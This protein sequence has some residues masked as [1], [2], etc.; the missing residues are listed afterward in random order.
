MCVCV[1][2]LSVYLKIYEI[3]GRIVLRFRLRLPMGCCTDSRNIPR[4]RNSSIISAMSKGRVDRVDSWKDFLVGIFLWK[5]LESVN[6]TIFCT[7]SDEDKQK[8]GVGHIVSLTY[9]RTLRT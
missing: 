4:Q 2:C 8:Y 5:C 7:P 3:G 6:L 1:R 9:T